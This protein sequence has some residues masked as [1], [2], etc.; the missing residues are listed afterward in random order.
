MRRFSRLFVVLAIL[1]SGTV[2]VPYASSPSERFGWQLFADAYKPDLSVTKA[3]SSDP[4]VV[5]D[6]L[7]YTLTVTN[8]GPSEATGVTINDKLPQNVTFGSA[9]PSQGTGC[10]GTS[11]ISCTL[12]TLANGAVATVMIVVTPTKV[13]LITNAAIVMGNEPDSNIA[14]NLATEYTNISAGLY[15][16]YLPQVMKNY[17]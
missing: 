15:R 6:S 5:G 12:S 10:S 14:N 1:L 9:T 7:T 11:T 17:Q 16:I 3:D 4:A 2:L 13:G 8:N